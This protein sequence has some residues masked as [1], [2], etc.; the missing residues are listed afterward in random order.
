MHHMTTGQV[1]KQAGVHVETIRFYERKGLLAE[2]PRRESGY[3]QYSH[4]AVN[5]IRFIKRAQELGFSLGEIQELLELKAESPDACPEVRTHAEEKIA[6]IEEKIHT[7]EGMR[8]ALHK[9]IAECG[10]HKP[11]EDCPILEALESENGR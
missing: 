9:L 7:L 5:R 11:A 6:D 3:R 8:R 4:Q 1:A 2:P 10:H